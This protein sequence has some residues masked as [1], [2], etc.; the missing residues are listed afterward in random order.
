[1]VMDKPTG[2]TLGEPD[3]TIWAEAPKVYLIECKKPGGKLSPV[4]QQTLAWLA[5]LGWTAHVITSYEEFL[6]IVYPK[7]PI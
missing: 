1:M 3:F 5:K 4:Q 6:A 7:A 2:R